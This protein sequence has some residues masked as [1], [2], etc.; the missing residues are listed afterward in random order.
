VKGICILDKIRDIT[1]VP[2]V[3]GLKELMDWR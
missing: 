3:L 1:A 2:S